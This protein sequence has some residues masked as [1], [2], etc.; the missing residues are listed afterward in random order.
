M[1]FMQQRLTVIRRPRPAPCQY[2]ASRC[3]H[4]RWNDWSRGVE[5]SS[6]ENPV[7]FTPPWRKSSSCSS[8]I[9]CWRA[10]HTHTSNGYRSRTECVHYWYLTAQVP[11]FNLPRR[12]CCTLNRFRTAQGRC[13]ARLTRWQQSTDPSCCC[14]A[15]QQTSLKTA[16][17]QGFLL[18]FRLYI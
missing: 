9:S 15:P 4:S 5:G 1:L 8:S 14:A 12:L 6:S 2:L 3:S 7:M 13:A 16:R 17:W 18:V 11:G 10:R